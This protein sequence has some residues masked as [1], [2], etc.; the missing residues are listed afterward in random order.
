MAR[1]SYT[2]LLTP[3]PLEGGFTITVPS[4]PGCITEAD[5]IEEAMTVA[6]EAI[7]LH[8]EGLAEDGEPIPIEETASR[9]ERVDVEVEALA[10]T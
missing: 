1:L 10:A 7:S 9:L 5:T 3:D 6:R 2:I 4:L 8:L